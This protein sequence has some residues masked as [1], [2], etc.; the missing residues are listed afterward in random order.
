MTAAPVAAVVGL[1]LRAA[2]GA[3][4]LTAA[5][6]VDVAPALSA[7]VTCAVKRPPAE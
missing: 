3:P 4:T 6:A 5:L 1:R 2:T 7:M